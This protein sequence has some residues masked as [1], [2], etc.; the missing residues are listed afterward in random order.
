[1][2]KINI[3]GYLDSFTILYYFR[4]F[5]K[6]VISR[7]QAAGVPE[8]EAVLESFQAAALRQLYGAFSFVYAGDRDVELRAG[9]RS[10][11]YAY[12]FGPALLK[13]R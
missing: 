1:M 12:F 8:Y 6:V 4:Y 5:G 13:S 2:V 11:M 7:G 9:F 10:S 3:R